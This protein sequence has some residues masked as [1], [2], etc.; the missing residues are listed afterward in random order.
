MFAE[1]SFDLSVSLQKELVDLLPERC[2]GYFA[3]EDLLT[4]LESRYLQ[5]WTFLLTFDLVACRGGSA[6]LLN[7][8]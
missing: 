3:K 1:T 2:Q 4:L 7:V 8:Q 5:R 6:I